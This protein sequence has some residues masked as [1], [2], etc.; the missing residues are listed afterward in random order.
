MTAIAKQ[1][2]TG[3]RALRLA[4][5]AMLATGVAGCE[6][7]NAI[8]P[9]S[10]KSSSQEIPDVPA[11]ELFNDGLARMQRQNF[12]G[13]AKKFADLDKQYPYS[14]WSKRSLILT[15]YARYENR[16]YE[17]AITAGR[18]FVQQFPADKDAAYAQ[19]IVGMSYFN[20]IPDI[21]RDQERTERALNALDELVRRW[22]DSEYSTDAR[23]RL[24]IA[25]DQLAGKEMDVGRFYLKRRNFTAAVNR[26]REVLIKYQ[27]TRHTEEALARLTEAYMALGIVNEAQ[28][29][30]AVL[31][32]N[33]PDSQWYKD[34]YKL[35]QSG[36]LEPREDTGSWISRTFRSA[37]RSVG[38]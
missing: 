26:F 11:E 15:A 7:I 20:Q 3:R 10:S 14:S 21:T 33:F 16:D 29:A 35:L 36:G 37:A 38:L 17:E 27:T 9:F 31:G 4:A 23:Q 32:H 2:S 25:R 30:A 13:A 34:S 5:V 18:R 8:N 19:Y 24:T 28:T 12:E 1:V 22:P 6:T